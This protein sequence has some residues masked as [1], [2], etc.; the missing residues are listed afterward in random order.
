[1]FTFWILILLLFFSP[2]HADLLELK[3]GEFLE[4]QFIG[5]KGNFI[6]YEVKGSTKRIPKT[7]VKKLEIGYNGTS[8]CYKR[9]NEVEDC[10]AILVHLD[11]KKMVIGKGKG[12]TIKEEILLTDLDYLHSENIRKKD[13]I[14]GVIKPKAKLR[15]NSSQTELKGFITGNDPVKGTVQFELDGKGEVIELSE[16]EITELHWKADLPFDWK[17]IPRIAI[18]G[19]YQ[20]PHNKWKSSG[21]ILLFLALG[22]AIP[23]E[24]GNAQKALEK[25]Q[26]V[27]LFNNTIYFLNGIGNNS[28]FE[29]HKRNRNIAIGGLGGLMLYHWVDVYITEKNSKGNATTIQLQMNPALIPNLGLL[30]ESNREMNIGLK[31]SYSF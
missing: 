20:W 8:F 22:A 18:P 14:A 29:N 16:S 7:N 21:M 1:M 19:V 13:R 9:L 25:D 5:E 6:E 24:H 28:A 31:F 26:E 10:N 4:G 30:P 17:F 23:V 2:I 15:I 11:D 12:S 27:L 3:S